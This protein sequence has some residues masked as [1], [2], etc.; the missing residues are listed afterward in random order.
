[1]DD[2]IGV[3][4]GEMLKILTFGRGGKREGERGRGKAEMFE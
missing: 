4:R 3:W 1:M 2:R